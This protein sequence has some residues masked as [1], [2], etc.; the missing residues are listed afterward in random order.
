MY[1]LD[2]AWY[3]TKVEFLDRDPETG[4]DYGGGG[5]TYTPR[6]EGHAR[7]HDLADLYDTEKRKEFGKKLATR[8]WIKT[9]LRFGYSLEEIYE[10]GVP[11]RII[12]ICDKETPDC[13]GECS[14]QSLCNHTRSIGHAANFEPIGN[15]GRYAEIGEDER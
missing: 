4:S 12:Y 8:V 11:G 13:A 3:T 15:Y 9:M 10:I 6:G 2:H 1:L 14:D 7:K 5:F